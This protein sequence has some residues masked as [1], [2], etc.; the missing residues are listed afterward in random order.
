MEDDEVDNEEQQEE[1]PVSEEEEKEEEDDSNNVDDIDQQQQEM[2]KVPSKFQPEKYDKND[3]NDDDDD[4][5]M[6]LPDMFKSFG[7][8]SS[9]QQQPTM[10]KNTAAFVANAKNKNNAAFVAIAKTNKRKIVADDDEE[11]DDNNEN[12]TNMSTFANTTELA[13]LEEIIVVNPTLEDL[14]ISPAVKES[15]EASFSKYSKRILTSVLNAINITNDIKKCTLELMEDFKEQLKDS[16]VENTENFIGEKVTT[17]LF[18]MCKSFY[19][20]NNISFTF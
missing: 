13:D 2:K 4:Q 19:S 17:L 7:R 16:K 14:G 12:A 3:D 15:L 8:K 11:D 10:N 20:N 5:S 9:N 1:D 6:D 18:N